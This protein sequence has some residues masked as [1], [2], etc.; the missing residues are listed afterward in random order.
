MSFLL[1]RCSSHINKICNITFNNKH[2]NFFKLNITM[3]LPNILIGVLINKYSKVHSIFDT[4]SIFLPSLF[5]HPVFLEQ[6]TANTL[7][8]T[9]LGTQHKYGPFGRHLCTQ[10]TGADGAHK[11]TEK[12]T[13]NNT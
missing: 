2:C 1:I 4:H 3:T 10:E 12:G 5:Q 7:Y 6:K 9:P 8:V 11:M 13:R